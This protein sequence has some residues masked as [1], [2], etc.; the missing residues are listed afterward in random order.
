LIVEAPAGS[1]DPSVRSGNAFKE[2]KKEKDLSIL[3]N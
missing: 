1:P 2:E 3:F